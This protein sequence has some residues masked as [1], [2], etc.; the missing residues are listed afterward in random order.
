MYA[1]VSE[2]MSPVDQIDQ[3]IAGFRNQ[4]VPTIEDTEGFVRAYLLV[5]RSSGKTLSITV[6]ENEEAMRAS[7]ESAAQLRASVTGEMG[8]TSTSVDRYEVVV[9]APEN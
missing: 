4:V 1:R 9:S 2:I 8:A 6:W 5:D 7:E 3:G